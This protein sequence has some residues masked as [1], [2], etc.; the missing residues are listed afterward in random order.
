MIFSV[1]GLASAAEVITAQDIQENIVT[2]EVLVRTADNVIVLV[3]TSSS[4]AFPSKKY[5]P[6]TKY[7]LEKEALA[8]GISRLPD[9]GYN[10]GI[11]SFTPWQEIYP[12]Q[13]F[14]PATAAASLDK[15]PA[16][17]SGR[18]PLVQGLQELENVLSGLSGKSVVYIFS[19]GGYDREV[20]GMAPGQKALEVADKY[21]VCFMI[22][23]HAADPDG[24]KRVR[25]MGKANPC[26]RVIP[27]DSYITDPYY[28]LAPLYYVKSDTE[29]VTTSEQVVKGMK[30]NNI[31]FEY[32]KSELRPEAQQELDALGTFLQEYPN[33][34]AYFVGYTDSVGS[35][36]YNLGLSERRAEAA[37]SYVGDK[38]GIDSTRLV[39]T[40]YGEINPVADNDTEEGRALNRRVEIAVGGF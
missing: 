10:L 30:V 16:E 23:S 24:R 31:L 36:D 14:D 6:K 11:Y 33:A 32:D 3:D 26:S 18:T 35:E 19:D 1:T 28:A 27:F 8:S 22:V 7:Q 40:W 12:V 34:S 29:V 21:N 9:L 39:T 38:F 4:M 25:D 15:L 5:K 37:A 2:K 13:P 17:A 20:A